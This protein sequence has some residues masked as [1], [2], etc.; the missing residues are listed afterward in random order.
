MFL[1]IL[2]ILFLGLLLVYFIFFR[3]VEPIYIFFFKK[4]LFIHGY[5]YLK[6]LN[7][8]QKEILFK[9]FSF[10]GSLSPKNKRYFEHRV[11][12]FLSNYE[13]VGKEIDI[14]E[15]MKML[16]AGTYVMLTFGM[17]NYL[18]GLF[19]KIMVYPTAYY[20]TLNNAYHKGEFNPRMKVIVFSW[21]DFL[22]GHATSNDNINLGLHEFSHALHFHCLKKND[23][24]AII[25]HDEFNKVIQYYNDTYLNTELR[26]K[27]YFRLYAYENQF[28]FL[29]VLLE[30]F[31]ETP[32]LFR[33]YHPELFTTISA[34]INF[35]E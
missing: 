17:R 15:E 3:I 1:Q 31:F 4:P 10:Y 20:S 8:I 16:I 33:K 2:F 29:S 26:V 34:M 13:F 23:P 25:F 32:D 24:S 35:S 7:Q 19:T 22:L 21:E 9:E 5:S 27:G 12:V 11:R 14:T 18:V 28:E 30:H 6:H